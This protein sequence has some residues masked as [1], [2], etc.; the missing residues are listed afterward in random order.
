M[1]I[2][3]RIC[4][5]VVFLFSLI[6]FLPK[7]NLYFQLK[8]QLQKYDI[9]IEN[10][11]IV[12]KLFYLNIKDASLIIKGIDVAK[13][14]DIKI[15]LYKAL[16]VSKINGKADINFNLVKFTI[17][18]EFEPTDEFKSKYKDSLSIFKKDENKRYIYEYKL[19]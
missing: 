11:K 15:Y 18:V 7:E 3:K 10:E 13:L 4:F 12:S 6:V 9:S 8:Q 16:V 14:D 19:L 5:V 17:V 1:N 2:C